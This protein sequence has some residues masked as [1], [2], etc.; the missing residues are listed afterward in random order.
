MATYWPSLGNSR[1]RKPNVIRRILLVL[2]VAALMAAMLA[3]TAGTALAQAQ[4]GLCL[5]EVEVGEETF[6]LNCRQAVLLPEELKG[7]NGGF[8]DP[9]SD[10]VY[11]QASN[12]C[13]AKGFDNRLDLA[14]HSFD[15]GGEAPEHVT[16]TFVRCFKGP[17]PI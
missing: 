13:K 9:T 12:S 3:G 11:G 5:D 15:Y 10:E 1:E 17:L 16:S 6:P 7:N 4:R 14:P 8:D 2:S